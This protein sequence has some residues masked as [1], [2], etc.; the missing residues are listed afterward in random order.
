MASTTSNYRPWRVLGPLIVLVVGLVAW[1]FWPGQSNTP[2]LGLDLQ[3]GTQVTLL[4]TAAPGAEGS[5][6]DEQLNQAVGIIRQRVNG[7]GVAESEV[8]IQGSGD[9]AAI[10][11]SVPGSVEQDRLVELVGRTAQLSFRAVEAVTNPE[12]I[13][14]QAPVDE[15]SVE[16]TPTQAEPSPTA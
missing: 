8:T 16:P 12:G 3:G 10:I 9:N 6:T 4:P 2:Q 15:P 7:L 13:D 5:I 1:A 11:V 14:P